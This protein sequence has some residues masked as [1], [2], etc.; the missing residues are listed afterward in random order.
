MKS[1]KHINN[2]VMIFYVLLVLF[3]LLL[4][5]NSFAQSPTITLGVNPEV[6][7]GTTSANLTYSATTNSPDQYSIDYD[8]TAETEGFSDITNAALP[9]SPINLVVPVAAAIGTYN[10]NLTVRNS[11]S[12]LSS[13]DYS[14]TVTVQDPTLADHSLTTCSSCHTFHNATGSTLTN[15]SSNEGLCLSCHTSGQIAE[16]M[17]FLTLDKAIPG[18]S[19]NSHAWDALAVN[20]TY[21]T[22]LPSNP[23]MAARL[24]VG[25]SIV[26]STCHDQHNS[27][28]ASPYLR[29]D[30]TDDAICK[31]CHSARDIGLYTDATPGYGSHPI[32][33]TVVYN[34]A[35]ARF[36][37]SPTALLAV[38][39]TDKIQCSTCHGV[40]DV[41]NSGTLTTDGYLLKSTNDNTL[42]LDCH[43]YASH[44]GQTCITCH[45][46]HNTNKNNIYM[47]RDLVT[48]PGSG[49][50]TVVFTA[51]TGTNSFADGDGTYDGVCEVCHTTNT[52]TYHY[53]DGTGDHT[54]E[55]GTNCTDCHIH[56]D[57][58]T[59]PACSDCHIANF[60]GWGTTDAHLAHTGTYSF[61]CNTC[62]FERGS[63]TDY[64]LF[65]D[66]LDVTDGIAEVNFN[67]S[68]LATRD[69]QDANT[70]VFNGDKTCSTVYCHSNGISAQAVTGTGGWILNSSAYTIPSLPDFVVA[71]AWD[72]GSVNCG[73]CHA[74][75]ATG[76]TWPSDAVDNG[77]HDRTKHKETC[78]WCHSV[79]DLTT[80]IGT[81]NTSFHVDGDVFFDARTFANGGTINTASGDSYE[82][83]HCGSGRDCWYP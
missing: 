10:G 41:T 50:K 51:E 26:C 22:N 79:D 33:N 56:E 70:P 7:Q 31:D 57:D 29:V 3:I 48:T 81:Y 80:Y 62:H 28:L 5:N 27:A 2:K 35:D 82:E 58:F 73:D 42:C 65:S 44:Q 66:P 24:T 59:A 71:P 25:D 60:P 12:G 6:Y 68:G 63:G 45:Q 18:T 49:D 32:G 40:H 53:N 64:H 23:E 30:N 37:A 43:A 75:D 34:D 47:I 67:P 8:A 15:F 16:T 55:A 83:G 76:T 13:G 78:S 1:T 4:S 72:T 46:V 69:G 52:S 11:G 19:G 14:I 21:E 54:H 74:A 9:S 61:T 36:N 20:S 38:N 39:N 77:N 17:P